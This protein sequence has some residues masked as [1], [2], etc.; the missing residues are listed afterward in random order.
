MTSRGS[1]YGSRIFPFPSSYAISVEPRERA[2]EGDTIPPSSRSA[3]VALWLAAATGTGIVLSLLALVGRGFDLTDEAFYLNA[4]AWAG[5]RASSTSFDFVLRPVFL[6][7]GEDIVLYR[8]FAIVMTAGLTGVA[9]FLLLRIVLSDGS[10]RAGVAIAL[11]PTGL[12]FYSFP[13]LTPSYNALA[14]WALLAILIGVLLLRMRP[15][16]LVAAW[17]LIGAGGWLAFM[18]KPPTAGA[19]ALAALLLMAAERRLAVANVLIPALISGGLLLMSAT[20]LSGG[21]LEYVADLQAATEIAALMDG[22]HGILAMLRI[23]TPTLGA[24][25]AAFLVGFGVLAAL[26]VMGAVPGERPRTLTVFAATAV[27]G[28]AVLVAAGV[29]AGP[30]PLREFIALIVLAIVLGIVGARVLLTRAFGP[31]PARG[32]LLVVGLLLLPCGF[33]LGTNNNYWWQSGLAAVFWVLAAIVLLGGSEGDTDRAA[34]RTA[35]VVWVVAVAQLAT[36]SLLALAVAHPYRQTEALRAMN[37]P[38]RLGPAGTELLMSEGTGTY[39]GEIAAAARAAGFAAGDPLLD[40]TGRSP[41]AVFALG[42]YPVAANWVIGGYRG[43]G[44]VAERLLSGVP[45]E[46]LAG[47]WVLTAPDGPRALSMAD[48]LPGEWS[49]TDVASVRFTD[50][51]QRSETQHLLRPDGNVVE[52]AAVCEALR[53]SSAASEGAGT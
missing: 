9:S 43:S 53:M 42:A 33:S 23:D 32:W 28:A 41:G 47:S 12:L 37:M 40:L 36:A 21:P 39:L 2:G 13:L 11:A 31:F 20:L 35:A 50:S 17:V 19:A 7:L 10:A 44:A 25:D 24:R 52:R 16:G 38:V 30:L 1:P 4:V 27:A 48:L 22:G 26:G 34:P 6:A 49:F 15:P 51:D 5:G 46:L 8:V 45:C 29:L 18:A 3:T 14:L